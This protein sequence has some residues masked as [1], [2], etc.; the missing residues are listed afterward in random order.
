[1]GMRTIHESN[2]TVT[3]RIQDGNSE[4]NKKI[5]E[6]KSHFYKF[7]QAHLTGWILRMMIYER[8]ELISQNCLLLK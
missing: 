6:I 4:A 5:N 2:Y 1:M 3:K 7:Y 8:N